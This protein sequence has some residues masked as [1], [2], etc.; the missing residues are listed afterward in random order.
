MSQDIG[1]TSQGDL[2]G[3]KLAKQ[4]ATRV[5]KAQRLVGDPVKTRRLKKAARQLK[6]LSKQLASV[7]SNG[8][9]NA[10]VGTTLATLAS[11]AQSEIAG[12]V[13]VR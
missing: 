6:A 4:L 8:K 9:V 2:G 5:A 7:M 10:D 12:L 11:D 1:A 13:T 3:K